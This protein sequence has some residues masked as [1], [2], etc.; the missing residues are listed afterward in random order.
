MP[1]G[2]K[3]SHQI[4]MYTMFTM[5]TKWKNQLQMGLNILIL[6]ISST[7]SFPLLSWAKIPFVSENPR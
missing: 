4:T 1:Q 6:E 2:I 5:E 3:T 7:M